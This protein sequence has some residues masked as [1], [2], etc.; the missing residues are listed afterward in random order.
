MTNATA[1][2]IAAR[3]LA[4]TFQIDP[5]GHVETTVLK[6]LLDPITNAEALIRSVG[7]AELN[8]KGKGLC[9]QMSAVWRKYPFNPTATA[10]ATVA[11]VNG[12]LHKPD[13]ALWALY[14]SSLQKLLVKQGGSYRSQSF[15]A[16]WR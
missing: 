5:D 9:S 7:P 16:E 1:A 13:G 14:D 11:D 6:L 15:R 12:L 4:Q 3:Q 8:G 10:Q 2:R